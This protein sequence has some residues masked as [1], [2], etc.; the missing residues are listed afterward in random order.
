M[1]GNELGFNNQS[2]G[3]DLYAGLYEYRTSKILALLISPILQTLSAFLAYGIIWYERFGTDNKRTLMNKLISLGLWASIVQLPLI[4]L[5]DLARFTFGPLPKQVCFMQV[6]FKHSLVTQ[7]LIFIDAVM[8][9]KYSLIFWTKNPSALKDDFWSRLIWI[10]ICC[11]SFLINFT[12]FFLAGFMPVNYYTCSNRDPAEDQCLA[13]TQQGGF[14][15]GSIVF[16]VL[17]KLRIDRHQKKVAAPNNSKNK[18]LVQLE[19]QSIPDFT[20]GLCAILMFVGFALFAAKMNSMTREEVNRFPTYL[21][22]Y[23]HQLILP[24]LMSCFISLLYYYRHPPLRESILLETKN[25]FAF[26]K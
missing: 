8:M 18:F 25:F 16:M 20:A 13:K 10:W 5:S 19:K 6:I 4:T 3:T 7:S 26:M 17:V 9:A 15:A 12:I 23:I 22:M 14:E 24:N 21:L 1:L 2:N 11:F